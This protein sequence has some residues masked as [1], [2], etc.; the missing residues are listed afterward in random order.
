MLWP[1]RSAYEIAV[2]NAFDCSVLDPK[3]K[4]AKPLKGI[5]GGFSR[6]YPVEVDSKILALRCWI[7]DI[8]DAKSHYAK[9]SAYL[10]QAALPYF[11]DFEYVSE[12]ILV[13][14]I[15]Y[16]ITRMEW[17]K[18][19]TIREFVTRHLHNV[20]ILK[21]ASDEFRKMIQFLHAHR[22][23]HGDLQ[24]GNILLWVNG[25]DV[26]IRLIDYDSIFVPTLRAQS[27]N[28]VG[29]PDYQ[30]P[31]R[32]TG[33]GK[34]SEKVDYFSELVIYLSLLGMSE[35]PELWDQ[36]KDRTE[37][38]LLFSAK[39]FKNPEA[40]DVF[41]ELGK[42][43]ENVKHLLATLRH[44]CKQPSI[45][46]LVPLEV[47]LPNKPKTSD[48]KADAKTDYNQAFTHLQNNRYD[49]AI[50]KFEKSLVQ[51]K[52][53]L[54]DAYYGLS[55]AYFKSG[56]FEKAKETVNEVLNID[57]D[58]QP[59]QQLLEFIQQAQYNKRWYN[60]D[61]NRRYSGVPFSTSN[62]ACIIILV[63]QSSSMSGKWQTVTKAE[64]VT[65]TVNRMIYDLCLSCNR[66][67]RIINRCSVSVIGYG[68]SVNC[69]VN[70]MISDVSTS[71]IE[72]E[73]VKRLIPDGSSG[74][75][76]VEAEV[77]IWVRPQAIGERQ[78]H[79]AFE[80]ASEIAR[81]WC[82]DW[83]NSFPPIVINI[84]GGFPNELDLAR[85]A[86]KKIMNLRTPDG[87]VLVFNV[88]IENSGSE[89]IFPHNKTQLSKNSCAEF[90]FDI[91]S[92]L[93]R[94]L[95]EEARNHGFS[96]QPNARCFGHNV[97]EIVN[98]LMFGS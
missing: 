79:I 25:T 80:R 75:V 29:L 37:H 94:V 91:S 73:K 33:R 35:K 49:E 11:V 86:A 14:G 32:V 44:F 56:K 20:E 34:V 39:D 8:G 2:M 9:V 71:P 51:I 22:I 40:S 74:V 97:S 1:T 66:G 18:G 27:N 96:P 55:L 64:S 52:L 13:D 41:Q 72:V 10:K 16:P 31:Q 78:M 92:I 46:Q 82:K 7:K 48:A 47:V 95:R 83:P 6:V 3:L 69:I 58:Y 62:P 45:E 12:G 70:G 88:C 43:S 50:N 24:S 89:V 61:S 98:L 19:E 59:A 53:N 17:A 67:S 36:F 15:K 77:P 81:Q 63:D 84:T 5:S 87:N 28:I 23:A 60:N 38:G 54:K 65:V 42:L 76:E 68:T 93:P 90:L 30:H 21:A 4:G 57:I 85:Q 26:E